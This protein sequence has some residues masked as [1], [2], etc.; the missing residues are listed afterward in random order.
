MG[1]IL[2]NEFQ[3][4]LRSL[5][6]NNVEYLLIGGYAVILNGH[7]RNTNDLDVCVSDDPE[8]AKRLVTALTDFGFDVPGLNESLFTKPKSVVR[9][10][11]PPIKIEIINYLEGVGFQNAYRNRNLI[12]IGDIEISLINI[13]DLIANKRTVARHQDLADV[14]KLERLR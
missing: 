5:N 8:N 14:E 6:S 11:F 1:I 4:F 3:E 7:V 13:D 12:T 9:M 10:G 2:E